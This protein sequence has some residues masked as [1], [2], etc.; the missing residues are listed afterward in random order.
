MRARADRAGRME[1]KT[2]ASMINRTKSIIVFSLLSILGGAV[3]CTAAGCA[4]RKKNPPNIPESATLRS[5]GNADMVAITAELGGGMAYL[6][7]LIDKKVVWSGE[8]YSGQ[9][10]TVNAKD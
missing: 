8:L 1:R 3:L 4:H 2:G 6:Y 9:T 7:D 5:G 10:A